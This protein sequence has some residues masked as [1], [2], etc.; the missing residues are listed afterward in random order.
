MKRIL[1]TLFSIFAAVGFAQKPATVSVKLSQDSIMIGDQ[2]TLSVLINKDIAEEVHVLQF[3]GGKIS[4]QLEVIGDPTL[5]TISQEGREIKLSLNYLLTSFEAGAHSLTGFPVVIGVENKFDTIKA[6]NEATLYVKTF[7][8]DT[9]KQ[10]IFDIKR[11]LDAPLVWAEVQPYVLWGLL[12]LAVLAAIVW[13]VI[14]FVRRR[15]ARVEARP[16]DPIH[17]VAIRRLEEL[18]NQKLWQSGKTKEYFSELTE[19][20]RTY[21]EERYGVDALEMTSAEILKSVK[22]LHNAKLIDT[23]RSMLTLSDL[24][25]FAKLTPDGGE[26]ETAYFDAYY[27]IEQTKEVIEEP[28]EK[29]E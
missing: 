11:P 20:V 15:K 9:T 26:C 3:E 8:I 7:D 10:Q 16:K 2:I 19:I 21:I 22:D 13:G 28:T 29:N 17:V 6:T 5:D 27:Y 18:H 12:G 1:V 23:L 14:W 24:A 25:K 4:D